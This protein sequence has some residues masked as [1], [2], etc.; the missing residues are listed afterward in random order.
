MQNLDGFNEREWGEMQIIL[1]IKRNQFNVQKMGK[2]E[3]KKSGCDGSKCD[4]NWERKG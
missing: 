4:G 1:E 2:N 3:N